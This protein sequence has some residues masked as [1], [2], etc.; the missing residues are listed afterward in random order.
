[1]HV[2]GGLASSRSYPS[3]SSKGHHVDPITIGAVA[4]AVGVVSFLGFETAAWS[5]LPSP[6]R[7][8]ISDSLRSLGAGSLADTL[9]R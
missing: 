7:V 2:P 9:P 5:I 8:E 6:Q 4:I 1:M 3:S